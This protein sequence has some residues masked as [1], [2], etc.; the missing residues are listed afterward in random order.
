MAI[1]IL[2]FAS[3]D[4]VP[5]FVGET[6]YGAGAISLGSIPIK[7]LCVGGISTDGDLTPDTEVRQIFS[8]G[9]AE[10]AA[11]A[12][13]E[14]YGMLANALMVPG[15]RIFAATATEAGGAAAATGT[16]TVGGTWSSAGTFV[17]RIGGI[18]VSGT[19]LGTD[20]VTTAGDAIE[21][22]INAV[23]ACPVTASN[24]SGT[25]TLTAK[26]KGARGNMLYVAQDATQLPSGCTSTLAGGTAV[27]GGITPLSGG[28]GSENVTTLLATL[29]AGTYDMQAW[30]IADATNLGRI[31]AQ[32]VAKAGPL[33]NRLEHAVFGANG[34][35]AA[36]KSLAQTTCNAERMQCVWQ[37]Y[38]E[39]HPSATAASMAAV[40]VQYMQATPN[41]NFDGVV[42]QGVAP[43]SQRA[44][45][46]IRATQQAALDAG[47]TP[48]VTTEGDLTSA[49]VVRAI[50]THCLDGS[51]PD[52]R[53]L[54]VSDATV[55]DYARRYLDLY[56]TTSYV[57]A[58]P[59][60]RADPTSEERDPPA[61]VATPSRWNSQVSTILQ[62]LEGAL[63]LTGTRTTAGQPLSEFDAT[64]KR[65][66]SA[67]PTFR[68]P[69]Q[70]AIGVSIRAQ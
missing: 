60:V 11:G 26:T 51:N 40:R 64:A 50:T 29:Y 8:A 34:T 30:A 57:V 58:N 53:T 10:T 17:Y 21:A 69:H 31:K 25:V 44:D 22:A 63:V 24:S 70:H 43:Q 54:D 20:S 2:G 27:T 1:T 13:S 37:L 52:Y 5:G 47:V 33:E 3:T 56:W 16:I 28:S 9:D 39:T 15:V 6:V 48:I 59:Y 49:Q 65:I 46:A 14:L 38:G 4:K 68:L 23:A 36:A 55:P 62:E 19:I 35:Y 66:M 12:G 45:W 7:L 18:Y 67:V 61:G 42:L 41:P 32:L